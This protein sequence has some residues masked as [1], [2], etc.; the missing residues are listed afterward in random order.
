[1]SLVIKFG[2]SKNPNS[3]SGAIY[4]D[5]VTRYGR[6]YSGKVTEHPLEAGAQITDH[7]I[8]NNPKFSIS[9]VISSVDFS[10][11]PS[12][13]SIDGEGVINNNAQPAAV[14]VKDMSGVKKF[15]PDVAAQFFGKKKPEVT[16]DMNQRV[17]YK[18][19][20]EDFLA[21]ILSGLQWNPKRQKLENKMTLAVLYEMVLGIPARPLR[22]LV[23]TSVNID[24]DEETGD[25]LILTVTFEQVM[26]VKSNTAKA[27]PKPKGKKATDTKDKG[28]KPAPVN[29]VKNPPKD[30]P[31]V[32]GE[33]DKAKK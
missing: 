21:E 11:I 19:M 8:S 31:T 15:L 13:L 1:M 28:N 29:D 22:D 23:C 16:M 32:M 33:L 6:D 25:A 26:F 2:D 30:K 17:N 18:Y 3:I 4:F 12:Q 5:A 10:N 7:Y 20:I 27:P 24:E 14:S 9:G